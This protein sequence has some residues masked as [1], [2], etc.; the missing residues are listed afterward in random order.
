M[1]KNRRFPTKAMLIVRAAVGGYLLYLSYGLYKDRAISTMSMAAMAAI[2]V[3]FVICGAGLLV[4]TGYLFM[5]GMYEGGPA[6]VSVDDKTS[7]VEDGPGR[8]ADPEA[9]TGKQDFTPTLDDKILSTEGAEDA[10]F[11]EVEE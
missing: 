11:H 3:I 9:D 5:K 8:D 1:N 2:I 10:E 4:H 7:D 6:D